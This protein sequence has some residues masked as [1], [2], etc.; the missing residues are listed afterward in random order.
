VEVIDLGLRLEEIK[1]LQRE[2]AFD[3]RTR[4]AKAQNLRENGT[5]DAEI[6]FLLDY[7]VELSAMTSDERVKFVERKLE[8][9]GIKKVIPDDEEVAETYRLFARS[10]EVEQSIEGEL[11]RLDD[12]DDA[13]EVPISKGAFANTWCTIPRPVGTLP[14]STWWQ[15]H[16][17]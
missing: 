13:A 14:C 3:K 9:H 2:D 17:N 6:N 7:R 10:Q 1:G 8:H 4:S 15:T 16:Q 11:E 12:Y 5:T